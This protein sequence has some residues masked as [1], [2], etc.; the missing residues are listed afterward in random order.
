MFTRTRKFFARFRREE[1]GSIVAETVIMFPT[2]FAACLATYVFFDAFRNQSVSLKAAYTISDALSREDGYI[3]NTYM[4]SLWRIHRFL[5]NSAHNTRLRVS[6]IEYDAD[7]DKYYVCW[8]RNKGGM[9]NLT[10]GGLQQLVN[11][12]QIPVLP[13][14]Q[15]VFLVQTSVAWEPIFSIGRNWSMDF[16]NLVVTAPRFSPATRYSHNGTA[17][18]EIG[19]SFQ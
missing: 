14:D 10:N 9:G 15:G 12:N 16:Q 2:L 7:D 4:N 5:T 17:G 18:G 1:E 3:T 8:S 11:A 13:E 19:C 6:M